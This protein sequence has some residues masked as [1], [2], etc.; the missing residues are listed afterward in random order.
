[1]K[2]S[3]WELSINMVIDRF[4]FKNNQITFFPCF[5]LPETGIELPDQELFFTANI[6]KKNR[7]V[8]FVH[9]IFFD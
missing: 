1:M 3:R 7:I 5:T 6:F 9:S 2:R 8:F 4:V